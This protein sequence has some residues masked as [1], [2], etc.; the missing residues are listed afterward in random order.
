MKNEQ[1]FTPSQV[2]SHRIADLK[3]EQQVLTLNLGS[4]RRELR[5]L[6]EQLKE[7]SENQCELFAIDTIDG[8]FPR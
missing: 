4:L 8:Q 7:L 2:V 5:I 3:V 6:E 1:G